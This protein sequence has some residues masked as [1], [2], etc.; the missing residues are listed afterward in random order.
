[1]MTRGVIFR[2]LNVVGRPW[3]GALAAVGA[4]IWIVAGALTSGGSGTALAAPQPPDLGDVVPICWGV[5]DDTTELLRFSL[6]KVNPLPPAVLQL[7]QLY[8][9]EGMAYRAS[10]HSLAIFTSP[11]RPGE[12]P[13]TAHLW[14]YDLE[15]NTETMTPTQLPGHVD[16]AAI[17]VDPSDPNREEMF[18]VV[19]ADLYQID[20]DTAAIIDGPHVLPGIGGSS[21]GLAFDP[22]TG[23]M[24]MTDDFPEAALY[25]IERPSFTAVKV[26][27]I[28]WPDGGRPDAESLDFG[29]GGE[30]YTEEDRGDHRGQRFILQIDPATGF[31]T[32]V[33]GPI[34]GVGDLEGLGCNGGAEV[35]QPVDPH[36]DLQKYVQGEDADTAPGP[37]I[38]TDE[39]AYFRYLVS[40]TGNLPLRDVVV[41]DDRGVVVVCPSGT[42]VIPLLPV[43]GFAECSGQSPG[44][45]EDYVNVGAVTGWA[46][47]PPRPDDLNP[48]P[49][50]VSDDDPAHYHGYQ[51]PPLTVPEGETTTSAD[52]TTTVAP[53]DPDGTYQFPSRQMSDQTSPPSIPADVTLPETGGVAGGGSKVAGAVVLLIA[54]ALM[55]SIARRRPVRE[56]LQ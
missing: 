5:N 43:G 41:T 33:A 29:A 7:S 3:R 49:V 15:T 32:P 22:H 31:V 28:R 4:G 54:G 13:M 37:N 45:A 12:P 48:P 21:G 24:W 42:A 8:Q 56:H 1:M 40:N 23:E 17:W 19:G 35:F 47:P 39:T 6:S 14:Y 38:G 27:D 44:L 11:A 55:V 51:W 50:P 2:M 16:A 10:T 30:L 52:G 36:I 46:D 9:G 26:V 53:R 25:R 18:I 20:P 34:P